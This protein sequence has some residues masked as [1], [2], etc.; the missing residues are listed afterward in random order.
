[1]EIVGIGISIGKLYC[2]V[3]VLDWLKFLCIGYKKASVGDG[4]K[5]SRPGW[6]EKPI[7]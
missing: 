1:M 7:C 4:E 6:K 3:L 5:N 2:Q